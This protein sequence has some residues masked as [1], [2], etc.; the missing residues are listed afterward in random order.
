MLKSWEADYFVATDW[1]D[2]P[3]VFTYIDKATGKEFC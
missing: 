2:D 1:P 3:K